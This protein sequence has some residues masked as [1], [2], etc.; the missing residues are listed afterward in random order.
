MSTDR[1]EKKILLQAPLERVWRAISDSREFGSWFGVK[2]DGPF[3]EEADLTGTIVPT[4]VDAQ[5]ARLQEPHAGK[6]FRFTVERIEPMRRCRFR[7]HPFA[8]D[9]R[10][11]YS[12]EPTTLIVFALEPRK[13]GVQLTIS[14]TGFDRLPEARRAS[15]YAAN[16]GGWSHQTRL[17]EKYLALQN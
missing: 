3:A 13:D 7:W 10:V 8:I 15:A 4:S 5:V 12:T 11:D 14:E 9:P 2:F 6:T 1:I 16:D 17:I